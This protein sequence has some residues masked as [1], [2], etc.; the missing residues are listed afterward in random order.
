MPLGIT[1]WPVFRRWFGNRSEQAAARFLRKLGYRILARNVNLSVG[2]LDLV[3]LDRDAL[4][5]VEVR[6]TQG[7][8]IERPTLSVDAVKQRKLTNA[9]LAFLSKHRLLD[10]PARFDVV[11]VSWPANRRTPH[12]VHYPNAFEPVGRFQMYN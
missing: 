5:F 6:S 9:A 11:I 12:V 7:E 1:R 8:A 3:A 2:E 4:V 10:R